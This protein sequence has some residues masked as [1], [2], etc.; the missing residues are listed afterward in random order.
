MQ[1]ADVAVKSGFVPKFNTMD[2]LMA[3]IDSQ[4]KADAN[5]ETNIGRSQGAKKFRARRKA[6]KKA[7]RS[8]NQNRGR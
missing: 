8:R 3:H 7:R 2:D 6:E 4:T 1:F 5:K